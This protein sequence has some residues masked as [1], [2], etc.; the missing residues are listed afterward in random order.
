[1]RRQFERYAN[2]LSRILGA[3]Q[4]L[5]AI[6]AFVIAGGI[7][8]AYQFASLRQTLRDDVEVQSAILADNIAASVM[9]QDA[10]AADEMLRSFGHA[11]Y[12]TSVVA[13]DQQGAVFAR[14]VARESPSATAPSTESNGVNDVSVTRSIRYRGA[15]LGHVVLVANTGGIITGL[16]RYVALFGLAS[17]VALLAAWLVMR[18]TRARMSKAERELDYLAYT[19]PVTSL[20]NR[21]A[22]YEAL[23]RELRNHA[24]SGRRLS[25]LIVDLD[26]FKSVNDTAGHG[27]GDQL[28]RKVGSALSAAVRTTDLVGRIGGDEFV[29]IVPNLQSRAEAFVIAAAVIEAFCKP[30]DVDGVERFATVSVG[31]SL[32]PDDAVAMSELVSSADI[33][34]Y[35]AKLAGKNRFSGFRAEMTR[36]AQRRVQ[37]ERELRKAMELDEL[38]VY[39]QPQCDCLSGEIVSFE[40]LVRWPHASEGFIPPAEFIPVAEESGLIGALGLWV[41]QRA[42]TDTRLWNDVH[43]VELGLAVNVSVRQLREQDF[44]EQVRQVLRE[45]GFPPDHLELELTES[46][47][48]G[49]VDAALDFMRELRAMGVKLSVDD[50][51]TGYSSLSYLQSFPLN[52][53]KIDRSF[54]QRLPDA[55]QTMTRAIISLAHSFEMT[56]VAEG[57]ESAPQLA[58]L[59]EAGCDAVQGYLLGRPMPASDV[60]ALLRR[61]AGATEIALD[62]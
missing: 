12:L 15:P 23:E 41:L 50:F 9:F 27:A 17:L 30:F 42:C 40:A 36:A 62:A 58:W 8:S 55:G 38:D 10:A 45:T 44:V 18:N 13:Y 26:N 2:P 33:A 21:R 3:G 5:A 32:F 43:G 7:L 28:L 35:H 49:D 47:L 60:N 51:G 14:Y 20:P 53:L 46:F 57:V 19:D 22:S 25:L 16:L 52:R 11:R 61:T 48:M 29:I 37:I 34:L 39:Y 54:I 59:Q 56:V 6:A 4:M 24:R 1:V 31:V